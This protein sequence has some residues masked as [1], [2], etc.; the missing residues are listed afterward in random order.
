MA[1]ALQFSVLAR[2]ARTSVPAVQ[3]GAAFVLAL[4]MAQGFASMARHPAK[5]YLVADRQRS[6]VSAKYVR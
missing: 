2:H 6:V 4:P 1:P 5:A 3:A